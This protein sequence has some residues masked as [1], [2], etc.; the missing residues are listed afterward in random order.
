[1]LLHI[2]VLLAGRL[3]RY[4]HW[5][6]LSQA[7]LSWIE[8]NWIKL[9]S[10][11]TKSYSIWIK[12]NWIELNRGL[13]WTGLNWIKPNWT[14]LNWNVHFLGFWKIVSHH[15]C[16][17]DCGPSALYFSDDDVQSVLRY[18]TGRGWGG[19]TSRP[20]FPL[21][22]GRQVQARGKEGGWWSGLGWFWF[23]IFS[24]CDS[25]VCNLVPLGGGF[26][27]NFESFVYVNYVSLR[28]NH[29]HGHGRTRKH[30]RSH[31][32]TY[33]HVHT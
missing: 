5:I 30:P 8:Q 2:Q 9:N 7:E 14:E 33:V 20:G 22:I 3:M 16:H 25:P 32:C 21:L 15:L 24:R 12:M 11:W 17:S 18:S 29:V 19:G 31:A 23:Q 1:M 13:N 4:P 26:I 27:F 6:G 10:I 28:K